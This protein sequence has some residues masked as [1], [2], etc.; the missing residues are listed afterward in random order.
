MKIHCDPWRE[1]GKITS[2]S[3]PPVVGLVVGYNVI[4]RLGAAVA[5]LARCFSG[6]CGSASLFPLAPDASP[7]TRS[8]GLRDD[9]RNGRFCPGCP[10]ASLLNHPVVVSQPAQ[11]GFLLLPYSRCGRWGFH[12]DSQVSGTGSR[13]VLSEGG[14]EWAGKTE[15][16]RGTH[17]R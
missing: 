14:C 9:P 7:F 10:T 13:A 17:T 2:T 8:T 5:C 11:P 3:F 16:T 1:M 12:A 15:P 4:S 6:G